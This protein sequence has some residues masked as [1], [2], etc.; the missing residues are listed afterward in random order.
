MP[1][2]EYKSWEQ[3]T[4]LG[5]SLK[6]VAPTGQYDTKKLVNNGSNRWAL[7]PEFGYSERWGHWL[8]D[9]YGGVWFFSANPEFWSHNSFFPGTRTQTEAPVGSFE[10]HLSYNIKPRLWVSLDGNFWFGGRTTVNGIVNV[11]TYQ[12]NSRVG[13]TAAIPLTKHQTLKISYNN[14]AYVLYGGS[15]QSVSVAWQDNWLGRPK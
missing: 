9:A 4:I 10:G 13:A 12:K 5:V 3:K 14:G 2:R 8:L 7:K 11:N 6:I 1:E 15:Y